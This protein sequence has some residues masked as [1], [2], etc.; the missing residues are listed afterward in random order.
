MIEIGMDC[1]Q[2]FQPEIYDIKKVKELYGDRLSF[3]GGISTQQCLPRT[4]A[5][6]VR[7]ETIRIMRILRKGG[8]LII[9]PTHSL[10]RDIP[11]ENILAMADVFMNQDKYL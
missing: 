11:P 4:D 9:A 8:G 3:W 6:G 7:K 1:Y 10:P 2:T 5:E